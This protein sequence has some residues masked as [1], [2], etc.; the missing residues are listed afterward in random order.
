MR[1][2]YSSHRSPRLVGAAI[3]AALTAM[4]GPTPVARAD[5]DAGITAP[6]PVEVSKAILD[7]V[8]APVQTETTLPIATASLES[9]PA[10]IVPS[11][12][13]APVMAEA[14][15][16]PGFVAPPALTPNT[17]STPDATASAPIASNA[18]PAASEASIQPPAEGSGDGRDGHLDSIA[19]APVDVAAPE[20]TAAVQSEADNLNVSIRVASPGAS[21][22]VSQVNAVIGATVDATALAAVALRPGPQQQHPWAPSPAG[23]VSQRA[24]TAVAPTADN[25]LIL[26]VGENMDQT[27]GSSG[28]CCAD[29]NEQRHLNICPTT[30][31]VSFTGT[32]ALRAV[33]LILGNIV[34]NSN[35]NEQYHPGVVQ[36]RPANVNISIRFGS[37]GNDGPVLQTN[38]VQIVNVV[39]IEVVH[40]VAAVLAPVLT[41]AAPALTLAAPVHQTL[42]P[43]GGDTSEPIGPALE[44]GPVAVGPAVLDVVL[45]PMV[46][47]RLLLTPGLGWSR[48]ISP[49]M[50]AIS[51]AAHGSRLLRSP[52]HGST[53]P[54]ITTA[55]N[56]QPRAAAAANAPRRPHPVPPSA[57]PTRVWTPLGASTVAPIPPSSGSGGGLPIML[58]VPFALVLLESGL[59]RRRASGAVP[60]GHIDRRPERPG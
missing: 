30:D 35:A 60:R 33:A 45:L 56:E 48:S 31:S 41:L 51:R 18:S 5:V 25:A 1:I 59:R 39:S 13:V 57:P 6:P 34:A 50:L 40:V 4:L 23:P 19:P 47:P 46:V 26:P 20:V 27:C 58:A 37:P 44:V 29:E 55:G 14:P 17:S 15:L 49:P 8:L 10:V 7:T 32:H 52:L 21:G 24:D 54:Q 42:E 36:Y 43:V 22:A 38:L 3:A 28:D 12:A 11:E 53:A 9:V 2:P 16:V